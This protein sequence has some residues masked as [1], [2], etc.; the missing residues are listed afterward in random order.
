MRVSSTNA[1]Q[2]KPVQIIDHASFDGL[3]S[4]ATIIDNIIVLGPGISGMQNRRMKIGV[5][6]CDDGSAR[7]HAG[8]PES[9]EQCHL[10]SI[11]VTVEENQFERSVADIGG[12]DLCR[13]P[14]YRGV[15]RRDGGGVVPI[16]R[17]NIPFRAYRLTEIPRRI[18]V[19]AT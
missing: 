9:M 15:V 7:D 4:P 3:V 1:S 5:M 17:V 16:D 13:V 10:G 6:Q 11:V 12:F 8:I 18:A 19:K 2:P 14:R